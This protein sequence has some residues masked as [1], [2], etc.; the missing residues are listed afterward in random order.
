M[1]VLYD[2]KMRSLRGLF[3]DRRGRIS[4]L[5]QALLVIL[6]IIVVIAFVPPIR[7][8]VLEMLRITSEK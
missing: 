7:D 5:A 8:V 3:E 4:P 6:L 1:V 2:K